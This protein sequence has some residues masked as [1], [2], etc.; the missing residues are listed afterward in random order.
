[1][2]INLIIDHFERYN[3]TCC[4]ITSPAHFGNKNENLLVIKKY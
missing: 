4:R 1:M 3:N 2:L